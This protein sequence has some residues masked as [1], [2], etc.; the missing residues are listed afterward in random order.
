[1][2]AVRS[3]SPVLVIATL[4]L[5]SSFSQAAGTEP[6]KCLD[7]QRV[8]AMLAHFKVSAQDDDGKEVRQYSVKD[9]CDN[10]D[11]TKL[12]LAL[13][14]IK[15]VS[16]I[17]VPSKERSDSGKAQSFEYI[18][19][20]IK[21]IILLPHNANI[22][23]FQEGGVV[24][25]SEKADK[26]MRLCM[27]DGGA[28]VSGLAMT[29]VHE[30]RHMDGFKHVK[31]THGIFMS[32]SYPECDRSFEEQGSHAFQLSYLLKLHKT[33]KND[34]DKFKVRM[35][36]VHTVEYAFNDAPFGLK[37]GGL[38]LD[39]QN[40]VLF[41]DGQQLTL[42]KAFEDNIVALANYNGYPVVFHE[43]G[44]VEAYTFLPA[45]DPIK[46][47]IV[48]HYQQLSPEDRAAIL[49]AYFG[50]KEQCYLLRAKI[51]CVQKEGFTHF[52]FDGITPVVFFD[53]PDMS[54]Y[55]LMRIMSDSGKIYNIPGSV[56]F[57]SKEKNFNSAFEFKKVVYPQGVSSYAVD[58]SGGLIGINPQG[59]VVYRANNEPSWRAIP[60]FDGITAKKVIPYYWSPQLQTTLN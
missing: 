25:D 12:I 28:S 11:F 42:I 8:N 32:L 26:T 34:G 1:M 7:P 49:D 18:T 47:P 10:A 22:C 33:L 38:I 51:A 23:G 27:L 13:E 6:A 4:L 19:S 9:H 17:K 24:L 3:L 37:K 55:F 21:N 30:A 15:T 53:E 45:W 41:F 60:D 58:N 35:L 48:S 43:N 40:R 16:K 56:L 5:F 44:K 39:S 29:L 36:I 52:V 14:Q 57:T 54:Q 59:T 31:C 20:R 46:G 2:N 50:N